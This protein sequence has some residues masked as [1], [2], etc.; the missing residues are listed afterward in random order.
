[1]LSFFNSVSVLRKTRCILRVFEVDVF[2]IC[3]GMDG[4]SVVKVFVENGQSF[5]SSHRERTDSEDKLLI[6]FINN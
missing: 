3:I 5:R 6:T 1:M 2:K 4:Y